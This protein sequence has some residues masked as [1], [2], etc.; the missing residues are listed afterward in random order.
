LSF[1]FGNSRLEIK[2]AM[3]RLRSAPPHPRVSR[4]STIICVKFL[5]FFR[6]VRSHGI[7][8]RVAQARSIGAERDHAGPLAW[9]RSQYAESSLSESGSSISK[10]GAR[11]T[12]VA[13][14]TMFTATPSPRPAMLN[15]GAIPSVCIVS[16]AGVWRSAELASDGTGTAAVAVAVAGHYEIRMNGSAIRPASGSARCHP[17]FGAGGYSAAAISGG[18]SM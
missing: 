7:G 11:A 6:L 9:T 5:T 1:D 16:P 15:L 17:T 14:A 18:A 12:A 3:N 2:R 10:P 13:S 8:R 4:A